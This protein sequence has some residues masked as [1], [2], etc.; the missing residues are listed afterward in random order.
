LTVFRGGFNGVRIER[1]AAYVIVP[2]RT[3]PALNA[4]DA[5]EAEFWRRLKTHEPSDLR[6]ITLTVGPNPDPA[7]CA[8]G[9]WL[10]VA[11]ISSKICR[12][13]EHRRPQEHCRNSWRA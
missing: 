3:L 1:R 5:S 10:S 12:R 7:T 6:N 11:K 9:K 8:K 13:I 4:W 2:T